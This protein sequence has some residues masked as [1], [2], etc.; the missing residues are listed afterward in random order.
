L[1]ATLFSTKQLLLLSRTSPNL[2]KGTVF[3]PRQNRE[4]PM[5]VRESRMVK[6]KKNKPLTFF[7]PLHISVLFYEHLQTKD[8]E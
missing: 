4:M 6:G 8:E 3:I 2:K 7:L 5:K 1:F